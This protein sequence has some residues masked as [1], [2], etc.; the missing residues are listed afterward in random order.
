[1]ATRRGFLGVLGALV[2]AG[3]AKALPVEVEVPPGAVTE[4]FYGAWGGVESAS[5]THSFSYNGPPPDHTHSHSIGPV[6]WMGSPHHLYH[7]CPCCA[8]RGGSYAQ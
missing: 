4:P 3:A 2:G 7:R 6:Y 5:H 8:A 1:M